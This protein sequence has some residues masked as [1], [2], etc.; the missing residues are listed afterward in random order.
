MN[1]RKLPSNPLK[2]WLATQG[3]ITPEVAGKWP[4]GGEGIGGVSRVCILPYWDM[5]IDVEVDVGIDSYVGCLKEVSK[6]VQV[7][8]NGKEAV[9]VLTLIILQYSGKGSLS[10][11]SIRVPFFHGPRPLECAGC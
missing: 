10:R 4:G 11:V 6:L 8:L 5:D 7:L 1:A 9:M 2:P 3:Y